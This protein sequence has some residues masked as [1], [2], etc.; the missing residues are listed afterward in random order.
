MINGTNPDFG[1]ELTTWVALITIMGK[2]IGTLEGCA[3]H[4]LKESLNDPCL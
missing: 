3:N 2:G 4:C 1:Y